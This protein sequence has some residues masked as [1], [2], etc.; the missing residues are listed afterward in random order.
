MLEQLANFEN[1]L[2]VARFTFWMGLMCV[3]FTV[4]YIVDK[5]ISRDHR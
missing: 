1:W 4:V 2:P 5:V 3:T